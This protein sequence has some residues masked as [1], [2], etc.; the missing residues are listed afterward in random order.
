MT[1]KRSLSIRRVGDLTRTPAGETG[2]EIGRLFT[3][4]EHGADFVFGYTWLPAGG[5]LSFDLSTEAPPNQEAYLIQAGEI[6]IVWDN[7]EARL[8]AGDA[9]FFPSGDRYD[10]RNDG[11]VEAVWIYVAT[12]PPR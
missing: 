4:E 10:V 8:S 6:S 1:D 5:S 9:A 2:G 12:P 3:H 7:G 11:Q